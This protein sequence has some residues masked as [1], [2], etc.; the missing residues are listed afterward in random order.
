MLKFFAVYGTYSLIGLERGSHLADEV[1][2]FM[3]DTIKIFLLP[4]IIIFAISII[5]RYFPP[6]KVKK[7]PSHK[8][9]FIGNVLAALLGIVTPFCSCSAVSLFVGI[10]TVTITAVGYLFNA[11]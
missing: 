4:S 9:E 5:R 8:K 1:E 10:M 6:E 2:F 11:I 7:I 3:Y